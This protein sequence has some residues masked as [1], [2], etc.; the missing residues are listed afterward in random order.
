MGGI[1]DKFVDEIMDDKVVP[2]V[3]RSG[4]RKRWAAV[5][6]CFALVV[7]CAAAMMG[8]GVNVDSGEMTLSGNVANIPVAQ[9]TIVMIDVNPSLQMEV[10]DRGTVV[11]A[12]AL[13]DDAAA[14]MEELKLVGMEYK[15]AVKKTVSVLQE[16]EFITD[17]KNSILVSVMNRELSDAEAIRAAVVETIQLVDENTDYD[18]SILSQVFEDISDYA[19]IAENYHMSTGR[20]ALIQK[21]CELFDEYN[22]DELAKCTVQTI[23]Q[24]FEYVP[25]P[26]FIQR[27]GTVAATVPESFRETLGLDDLS[28]ADLINFTCAISDFYDKL[29]EYYDEPDVAKHIGFAFDI[30]CT[31]NKDGS[32]LWAVFAENLNDELE[33]LGAIINMGERA[34]SDWYSADTVNDIINFIKY[35]DKIV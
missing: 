20:A 12:E 5:A 26:D 29:C 27:I 15:E 32:K 21:T 17:L 1:D 2:M 8:I 35:I 4:N 19:E 7:L 31:E 24:I 25:V 6:A 16:H 28:A 18:L 11:S 30:A 34:I 3:R 14:L 10:N 9:N 23:N 22:F 33:S 13:N